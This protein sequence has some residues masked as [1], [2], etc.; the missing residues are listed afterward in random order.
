[1]VKWLFPRPKQS[2]GSI[3][4]LLPIFADA[5]VTPSI[6]NTIRNSRKRGKDLCLN[7]KSGEG[8]QFSFRL[9]NSNNNYSQQ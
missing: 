2:S 9:S 1:M 3:L 6:I 7:P 5:L 4:L 8:L